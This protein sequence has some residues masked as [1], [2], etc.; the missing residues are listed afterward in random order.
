MSATA[1]PRRGPI[2]AYVRLMRPAEWPF[3][4]L[5]TAVG[6]LVAAGWR[7]PDAPAWIGIG[8]WVVLLNGGTLALNSAYDR[9]STEVAFLKHPPQPPRYLAP[10]AVGLMLAGLLATWHLPTLYRIGYDVCVILS[11]AYSAPPFRLKAVPGADWLVNVIGFGAATPFAAWA[12]TGRPLSGPLVSVLLSF[13]P[14]FAGFYPLTQLYHLDA[15]RARGDRTLAMQ[16]GVRVSVIAAVFFCSMAFGML[17]MAAWRAGWRGDQLARWC[18][19]VLAALAWGAVLVPWYRQGEQWS[20]A[21]HRRAMYHA[22][23]AWALTDAAVI[24]GWSL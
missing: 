4:A 3:M 12:L 14:L 11:I 10:F 9:D 21:D 15:D 5:H 8:T 19:L 18:A 7:V 24:L 16:L 23:V 2:G 17:A 22:L 6:W 13:A 1:A 20:A